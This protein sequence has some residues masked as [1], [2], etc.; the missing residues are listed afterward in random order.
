VPRIEQDVASPLLQIDF[1]SVVDQ[2][3][4]NGSVKKASVYA[5][6]TRLS[7]DDNVIFVDDVKVFRHRSTFGHDRA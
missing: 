2:E 7:V 6:T 1:S 3:D 5:L 4:E